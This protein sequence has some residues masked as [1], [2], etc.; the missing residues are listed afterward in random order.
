MICIG[1]CGPR[2]CPGRVL[3]WRPRGAS[4][5]VEFARQ[6]EKILAELIVLDADIYGLT[7]MENDGYGASSA[8][9]RT[10]RSGKSMSSVS[11]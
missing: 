7:E 3:P 6:R 1:L 10:R 5:A 8:L 4:N 11:W 2:T 9:R